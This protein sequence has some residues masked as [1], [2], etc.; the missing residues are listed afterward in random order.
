MKHN[1]QMN[2]FEERFSEEIDHIIAVTGPSGVGAGKA[3]ISLDRFY[4]TD[5]ME[6][7]RP[8]QNRKHKALLVN[9]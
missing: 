1:K 3:G 4:S 2:A 7:K 9:R 8:H 5:C 6:G